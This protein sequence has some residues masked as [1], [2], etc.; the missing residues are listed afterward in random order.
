MQLFILIAATLIAVVQPQDTTRRVHD[1]AE[2]LSPEQ[3][4]ALEA[5][6]RDVEQQTTAQMAIVTVRSLD[7]LSVDEYAHELFKQ[8][9]IGRQKV[10]N[11]VLLLVAPNERRMRI[12]VG[13]GLE[14]LLSDSRCGEIR[15]NLIVPRFRQN[16]YAGGVEAGT[17]ELARLLL[18]NPAAARGDPN[19]GPALVK[20]AR[21][22][23]VFA[24]AGVAIAAAVL[25]AIGLVVATRRLYSTTTF[26]LATAIVGVLMVV[27]AY[28]LWLTPNR[29]QPL[30]WFGGATA[31][32]LAAWGFNLVTYRRFG[33]H[34]CS[35]CGTQ[36]ELLSEQHDD[37]KLSSVQQLEEKLGS[38]DYDVWICTACLNQDTEQYIKRFSGYS[39]CPKCNARTFKEGSQ[40]I[41][42]RATTTHHGIAYVE[43]HC[44]ACNHKTKRQVLLPVIATPSVSSGSSGSSGSSF[45]GGGFGGGGGGGGFGGG[46][47]GGG[48]ASGG[49]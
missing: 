18:A 30:A 20:R 6:A 37:P 35:K 42:R 13:F 8:W 5:V 34:H 28:Y 25:A 39:V 2:L 33:P 47:S 49:W 3:R 1:F 43:G 12:E 21:L 31:A 40:R 9:G 41:A 27:A 17:H 45:G 19:S 11:G 26:V 48:G 22:H 29:E 46:S 36:L 23:A 44:E 24:T 14:P 32:S 16:D 7:G 10:N 4:D 38:V 15:D